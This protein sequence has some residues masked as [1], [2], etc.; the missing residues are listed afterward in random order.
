MLFSEPRM[1]QDLLVSIFSE[2][3]V[4]KLDFSTLEKPN[5]SYI[6]KHLQK[7]ENDIVWKVQWNKKEWLYLILILEFQSTV[8]QFMAVRLLSY[9]SLLYEDL[10]KSEHCIRKSG[11]LPPVM[12]A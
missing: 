7:R 3:W 4:K 11:K 6:S 1:V 2:D 10:V 5:K 9:I 8:D 12:I